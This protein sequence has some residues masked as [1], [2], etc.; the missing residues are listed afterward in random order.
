MSTEQSFSIHLT[1]APHGRV[2]LR[3][4][5]RAVTPSTTETPARVARL[6]ALAHKIEGLVASGEVKDYA[7]VALVGGVTRARMSQIVGMLCLAPDIQE[8]VLE[9]RRPSKGRELIGEQHLR[10]IAGEPDWKKQRAAFAALVG[11]RNRN[12]QPEE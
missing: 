12:T 11:K 8:R 7:E 6:L 1:R 10:G 4:G 2:E 5:K 9:M 3:E